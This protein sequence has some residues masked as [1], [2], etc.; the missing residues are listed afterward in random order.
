[1]ISAKHNHAASAAFSVPPVRLRTIIPLHK[2]PL[3]PRAAITG[4]FTINLLCDI[5]PS[6]DIERDA[7]LN[8]EN[9]ILARADLN[10]GSRLTG[11]FEI[12]FG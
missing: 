9:N 10:D 6:Y 12:K 11:K 4:A 7:F 2:T 8:D 1:M 5:D 3:R